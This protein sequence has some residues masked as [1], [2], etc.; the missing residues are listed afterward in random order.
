MVAHHLFSTLVAMFQADS[1]DSEPPEY[2]EPSAW[3][4]NILDVDATI[5]ESD[6]DELKAWRATDP[7]QGV[8]ETQWGNDLVNNNVPR[9]GCMMAALPRDVE[10]QYSL[11]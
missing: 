10:D 4:K 8:L 9:V 2:A 7:V 3:D 6:A 11:A 1:L 5:M